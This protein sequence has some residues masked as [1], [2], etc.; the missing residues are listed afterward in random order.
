MPLNFSRHN[1]QTGLGWALLALCFAVPWLIPVRTEPW[2]TLF[3]EV[4]ACLAV[5]SLGITAFGIRPRIALDAL[6]LGFILVA[7]VPLVQA[8]MGMFLFP[9]ETLVVSLY[10]VGIGLTVALARLWEEHAPGRLPEAL[11]A[12]LVIAALASTALALGQ[13]L[14]LDWALL[15]APAASDSRPVA[16]VGQPN[17]LSTLLVWGLV[18][19]WWAFSQRKIGGAVAILAAAAMLLGVVSTQ[20]RTG[21]LAVV[22]LL[23]TA[24]VSPKQLNSAKHR[25]AFIALAMWFVILVLSW[26][27]IASLIGIDQLDDFKSRLTATGRPEIWAMMIDGIWHRPW[28]GYGWNQG[29]LVQLYELPNYSDLKVGVQ[30]AHNLVLDLMVWNG[31]PLGLGFAALLAAW[32]WLQWRHASTAAEVL[33]LLALVSFML[34]CML[35]LPHCK[36][37]FLVPAALMMGV[38]NSRSSLPILMRMPRVLSALAVAALSSVL[39]L[40]WIEY[41][42]IQLDLQAYRFRAAR[43]GIHPPAPTPAIYV[44]TGL[45][46]ALL[47]LRIEPSANMSARELEK[48][49]VT[50]I[51]Y[52]IES[53]LYKYAKAAA[54]NGQP[55][56]AQQSLIHW[57]LLFSTKSCD[58]A[59]IA[60]KVFNQ[61]YPDSVPIPFPIIK[62]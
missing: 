62:E 39:V 5:A 34:H 43:I 31:V 33:L 16:N 59:K 8:A 12:G 51:R 20:S 30:H 60:W 32:F 40:T 49:R 22:L 41:R 9:G 28:V 4:V 1:Q 2:P 21:W 24:M 14:Q 46:S 38:L 27:W 7:T 37:F 47:N 19:L 10:L 3:S 36:A 11:F 45:Q 35:E 52:P 26:S 61:E 42:A 53:A 15:L 29:R 48:L 44:L 55:I 58:K 50:A 6:S 57:C 56:A 18:G 13:V 23:A 25:G 54:L 17:E